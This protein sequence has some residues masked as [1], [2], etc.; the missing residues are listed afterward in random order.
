MDN[1]SFLFYRRLFNNLSRDFLVILCF[2]IPFMRIVMS[3]TLSSPG[4]VHI[5]LNK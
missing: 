3:I 2:V 4:S 5:R 1:L